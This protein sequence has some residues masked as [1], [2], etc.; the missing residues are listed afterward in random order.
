PTRRRCCSPVPTSLITEP[1]PR[2]P[3]SKGG[4]MGWT[5]RELLRAGATT[6]ATVLVAP[7]ALLRAPDARAAGAEPVLVS[8]V[9]RGGADCL[10]L[11][12]PIGDSQYYALRPQLAIARR[13]AIDLDGFFGLHP[14]LQ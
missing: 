2:S 9:L 11:V 10:S 14:A 7:T 3:I 8:L 6:A 4:D 12:P 5:R 1:S 13:D